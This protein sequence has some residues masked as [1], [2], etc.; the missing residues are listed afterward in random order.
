MDRTAN[1]ARMAI[2]VALLILAGCVQIPEVCSTCESPWESTGINSSF[3][4]PA[5]PGYAAYAESRTD[6]LWNAKYFPEWLDHERQEALIKQIAPGRH[7]PSHE[8]CPQV[9]SRGVILVHGLFDTP[10][11]MRDLA[12]HLTS[13]CYVVYDVMLTGHGTRPGD[14]LNVTRDEWKREVSYVVE[15]VGKEHKE[16]YIGGFSLGGALSLYAAN[17]FDVIKGV[18]LFAPAFAP[19]NKAAYG[20]VPISVFNGRYFKV[21][22]EYDFAKYESLSHRAG[23]QTYL[24]GGEVAKLLKKGVDKP[25]FVAVSLEDDTIDAAYTV[26]RVRAGPFNRMVV[27]AGDAKEAASLCSA[28]EARNGDGRCRVVPTAN[29]DSG[30]KSLSHIGLLISPDNDHYGKNGDYRN[31]LYAMSNKRLC[32]E[33]EITQAT[34]ENSILCYGEAITDTEKPVIRRITF[35]PRFAALLSEVD[36]FLTAMEKKENGN[37]E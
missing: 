28:Y 7:S 16:L 5:K 23:A 24:L 3:I 14:L 33:G 27:F 13:R 26:E 2:M 17:K 30:I 6:T 1:R 22:E 12:R 19:T 34:C 36:C 11:I 4:R 31:C 21:F 10:F 20:S 8:S 15:Q 9:K 35:N 29:M 32:L 25:L 18:M 37:G